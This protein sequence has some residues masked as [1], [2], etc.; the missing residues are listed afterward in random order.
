MT[1][2]RRPG[3]PCA[4]RLVAPALLAAVI[5]VLAGGCSSEPASVS[6]GD[7]TLQVEVADNGPERSVGL[8]GRTEVPAGTGMAFVFDSPTRPSFWM[9]DTVVPLSIVW[10]LDGVVVDVAEMQPCPPG[11][12]CPRYEPSDPDA[13][14]DLAVEAPGGTFTDAGVQPGDAVVT[15]GF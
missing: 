8:S 7:L 10:V 1:A 3:R 2:R 14:F 13:R 5:A 4:A 9:Q 15:A 6:V 11:T 12:A